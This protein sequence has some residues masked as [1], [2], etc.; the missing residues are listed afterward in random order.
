VVAEAYK[1]RLHA[2]LPPD[3][4]HFRDHK[5]QEVDLVLEGASRIVLTEVKSGATV[6]EDMF[7]TLEKLA[8]L[9][10]AKGAHQI[11]EQ[12]IVYGGDSAQRR[13]HAAVIPWS[14]VAD[15]DWGV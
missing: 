4:F 1:A 13:S 12:Q 6:Q 8:A 7:V 3:A 9:A 5:G 2:G 10:A 11:I 14:Q 15:V